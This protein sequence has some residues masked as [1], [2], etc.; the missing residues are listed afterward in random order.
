VLTKSIS[1]VK[2]GF[3]ALAVQRVVVKLFDGLIC[4]VVRVH[5]IKSNVS[6]ADWG[7]ISCQRKVNETNVSV[8]RNH[9]SESRLGHIIRQVSDVHSVLGHRVPVLVLIGL[10]VLLFRRAVI[11]LVISAYW[12]SLASVVIAALAVVSI[13]V[14]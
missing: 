13:A 11:G 4:C 14:V 10:S 12:R 1:L 2:S 6:I 8:L 7:I 9:E 5:T 3:E